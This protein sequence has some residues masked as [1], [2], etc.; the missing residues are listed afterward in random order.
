MRLCAIRAGWTANRSGARKRREARQRA[1]NVGIQVRGKK[2]NR[3]DSKRGRTPC[4]ATGGPHI[5]A[6]R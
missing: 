6:T 4:N 1:E 5:G 3:G 2:A